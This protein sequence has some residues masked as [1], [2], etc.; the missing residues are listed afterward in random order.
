MARIRTIKPEFWTSSTVVDLDPFTR[1]L[2]IGS[3]NF[4]DDHG[5][6]PDDPKRLK[7]Q[8][9]PADAV[10]ADALVEEL[11]KVGLFQRVTAPNGDRLLRISTFGAHQKIDKR[12]SGKWG[13]PDNWPTESQPIPP[14]PAE[15]HQTPPNS[16]PGMEGNGSSRDTSELR[17]ESADIDPDDDD[18]VDQ[19]IAAVARARL[20]AK[21]QRDTVGRPAA[22]LNTVTKSIRGDPLYMAELRRVCD[23]WP[24]APA[25]MLAQA[26]EGSPSPHLNTYERAAS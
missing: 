5:L 17:R 9:L 21:Q 11:V 12:S 16:S 7:L 20:K 18:K 6:M 22:W 23:K 19:V 4:A 24:N 25:D 10:D 14:S 1:L 13:N 3:W 15:S 26:A 8:V 2:F